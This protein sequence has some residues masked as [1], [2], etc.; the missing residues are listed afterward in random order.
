MADFD[1]FAGTLLE[2]SK[3]FLEKAAENKNDDAAHAAYLHASLN[4][5]FA[6]AEAHINAVAE[7]LASHTEFSAPHD[8]GVLLEKEVR[9]DNGE[10]KLKGDRF[11]PLEE[12][13]MFIH[14][15]VTSQPLDKKTQWWS[16]LGSAIKLR[17]KLTHPKDEAPVI[18]AKDV[19]A[20]LTAVIEC[21]DAIYRAVYKKPFP[22]A[23][24]MLQ[25]KLTF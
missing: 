10:F 21:I 20:A 14:R 25:S 11:Y 19:A 1:T 2:E 17:N 8:K 5:A 15:R 13:V 6:S 23:K 3:R 4:L 22:A 16:D 9:L 12:R 24:R 7:E 18:R